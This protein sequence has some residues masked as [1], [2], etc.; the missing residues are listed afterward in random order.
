MISANQTVAERHRR[1]LSQLFFVIRWQPSCKNCH[2]SE[3]TTK[4]PSPN[5]IILL[6]HWVAMTRT[7]ECLT[8]PA[9]RNSTGKAFPYYGTS[10]NKN[11]HHESDTVSACQVVVNGTEIL[12]AKKVATLIVTTEQE[13]VEQVITMSS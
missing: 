8:A 7:T 12:L 3:F 5:Q 10:N 2:G 13:V 11:F 6:I 1:I 4:P 9:G